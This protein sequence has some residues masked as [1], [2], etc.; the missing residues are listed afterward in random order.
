LGLFGVFFSSLIGVI[1]R[2]IKKIVALRTLSQISLCFIRF[3]LGFWFLG[4][5]HLFRHAFFKSFLFIQIGVIISLN[6]GQQDKRFVKC[7]D[8]NF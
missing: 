4:F 3:S 5:F 6:L 7:V 8:N 2:D 1:E